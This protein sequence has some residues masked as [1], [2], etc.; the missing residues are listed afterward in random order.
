MREFKKENKVFIK[1]NNSTSKIFNRY[2]YC[3]IP[4]LL[5]IVFYNLIWGSNIYVLNLFKSIFISLLISIL[6]QYIF[7]LIKKEYNISKVFL[8]DQILTIS[9]ILGLF[10]INSNIFLIIISSLVTVII[11]NIFRDINISSTLY[12]MLVILLYSYYT[13]DLNTPLTNLKELSYVGTYEL[14]VTP[15]GGIVD[16]L[17]GLNNIYLSPILSV[18]AFIYLFNKKSIKYNIV[19]SYILTFFIIMLLFGL[20][21]NMNIWY[22][23]LQLTTGNILFL[24][25]FCLTDYTN[26]PTTGEGQI[27]YGII[28]GIL[29]SVLRFVVPDLSV[30]ISLILGPILL[31]KIINRISFKLKYD[32]K[33]YY[34]ILSISIIL[35]LITL[36]LLNILI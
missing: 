14:M 20:F 17:F 36:I 9:I 32:K 24:S 2:L 28:L 1:S 10:S 8:H 22:L 11:K 29:T 15:H 4:F 30:V 27:I 3:L 18:I 26:T 6:T 12:G 31:T 13:N 25:V 5:L 23:F 19:F 35:V 33:Y 34:L 21:N 7:N 16:Y